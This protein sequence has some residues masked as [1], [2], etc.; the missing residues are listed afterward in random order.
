MICITG[1]SAGGHLTALAGLTVND[2]D[3]QPG[4][5]DADT[6]L[7]A[8]VPFYGI[9]DLT[10]S[11][12]F[13]YPQ[14]RDWVYERIVFKRPF[15]EAEELYRSA[16]PSFRVHADAPP[17]LV[18]HGERDTLVPVEDA[19]DFVD[20]LREVSARR[21]ATSSFREPS[22]RS[23]SGPR[24]AAPGSPRASAASSPPSPASAA[25]ARRRC[26]RRPPKADL[27]APA[28]D[29]IGHSVR[30]LCSM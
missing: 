3:Y 24:S 20:R 2:P 27:T 23:T 22:T 26:W 1:G 18:I 29:G 9:Y 19:R 7:A 4:F 12:G 25:A 16:S 6:S 15:A 21:S 10:D 17:F 28:H 13:Y 11:N 5:E 30:T 8:V 14:I